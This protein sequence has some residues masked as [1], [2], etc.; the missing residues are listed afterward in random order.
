M[1]RGEKH[2]RPVAVGGRSEAVQGWSTD[3]NV[4]T[5]VCVRATS[6]KKSLFVFCRTK[7]KSPNQNEKLSF[8]VAQIETRIPRI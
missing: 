3:G 8:R 7:V 4:V 2:G 6:S 1:V 5:V